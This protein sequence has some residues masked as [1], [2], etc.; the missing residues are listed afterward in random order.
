MFAF[1]AKSFLLIAGISAM[2]L[3]T[4]PMIKSA[5]VHQGI[6]ITWPSICSNIKAESADGALHDIVQISADHFAKKAFINI[7]RDQLSVLFPGWRS[8][9]EPQKDV[10]SL[11]EI[12]RGL[13][14]LRDLDEV[15]FQHGPNVHF[16]VALNSFRS[17]LIREYPENLVLKELEL[18]CLDRLRERHQNKNLGSLQVDR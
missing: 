18:K 17:D 6:S 3:R 1:L 13:I 7:D 8:S 11:S 10:Q 12:I 4:G 14:S 9:G 16:P 2:Q 15:N 5:A